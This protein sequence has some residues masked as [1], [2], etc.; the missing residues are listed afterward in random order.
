L[1]TFPLFKQRVQTFM[2]FFFE[3]TIVFTFT[4]FGFQTRRK[5][6]FAWLTVLPLTVPFPQ[7]SHRLAINIRLLN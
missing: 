2:V 3:P 5:A 6:F 1:T 7:I 4:R